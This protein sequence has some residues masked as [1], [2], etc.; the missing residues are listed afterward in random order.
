M[1]VDS[2]SERP[3]RGLQPYTEEDREYFFGRD[4]DRVVIA[5]NLIASPL[6]IL[7]GAS[8]VGKTSVLLA[9]VVPYL[10]AQAAASPRNT[11]SSRLTT[12]TFRAWQRSDFPLAL[13]L[14]VLNAVRATRLREDGTDS[15]I[16]IDP[17]LPLDEYLS[18]CIDVLEGR[19]LFIF[20]QFEEYFLNALNLPEIQR[21]EAEFARVI[22][23]RDID[24][25]F[26]L[27]LREE[28]LSKLDRFQGRI[29][30]LLNNTLRIEHLSRETGRDAITK[31]L[32]RYNQKFNLTD[33]AKIKIEDTLVEAVLDK[34]TPQ[35]EFAGA[36]AKLLEQSS[37]AD[38]R[39]VETPVLQ[40]L[41]TTL[42]SAEMKQNSKV[43]RLQ[44]FNERLGGA[45]KIVS[46]FFNDVMQRLSEPER[47]M[48]ARIFQFLV[49]Q[50]GT[51]IA[52]EPKTLVSWTGLKGDNVEKDVVAL[53]DKLSGYQ[54]GPNGEKSA[55]QQDFRVVRKVTAP[56]H[57]DRYELFHDVLGGAIKEW[58]TNY[59]EAK[60]AGAEKRKQQLKGGWLATGIFMATLTAFTIWF[61]SDA[62]KERKLATTQLN[63]VKILYDAVTT[64][65][66]SVPFFQAV[67][68]GHTDQVRSAAFS[69]DMQLVVT[70]SA[71]GTARV[72]YAQLGALKFDMRGHSG[73]VN[74]A[75][76]SEDGKLIVTAGADRT[77]RVWDASNGALL[78][79]LQGHADN[80]TYAA[81]APNGSIVTA[82]Q[83]GTARI[84]DGQS[85]QTLHDLRG[86]TGP[87]NSATL[88]P[89]QTPSLLTAS[90]DGTARLWD[91]QSGATIQVFKV[92]PTVEVEVKDAAI[93][94]D[95]NL[96]VTANADNTASLFEKAS[97]QGVALLNGHTDVV[98]SASFSP[99]GQFVVTASAD[100]TAR[101]WDAKSGRSHVVLTG[102]R[103]EVTDA[104]FSSDG[105]WVITIS[106]DDTARVWEVA[107]GK[108]LAELRGH[109][110]DLTS[111]SLNPGGKRI[112]TAS[113][114]KTARVWNVTELS[115][116][117]IVKPKLTAEPSNYTGKC[118][119]TI[120]FTGTIEVAGSGGKVKYQFV[121]SSKERS[122][123][124]ELVFT[125]PGSKEVTDTWRLGDPYG[126]QTL[127]ILEPQE[128]SSD[129]A[130]FRINCPPPSPTPTPDVTASP[131]PETYSVI[132]EI[133]MERPR[134]SVPELVR[135]TVLD[136]AT[137]QQVYARWA[138]APS[139]IKLQL[140][141][142]HRYTVSA[143]AA[144]YRATREVLT[145]VGGKGG[146]VRLRLR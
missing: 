126:W 6:T 1:Q 116:M 132:C 127:K 143:S 121:R 78:H 110:A 39:G 103:D 25:H 109:T 11:T 95:G 70:A 135:V 34:A 80:V 60:L 64:L 108:A 96:V 47:E 88:V 134:P 115:T 123:P 139:S 35:S 12:V 10:N 50:S 111:L 20:D 15:E 19:L 117:E 91:I 85:G 86:H 40:I 57:P 112:A 23:R 113:V 62:R 17:N 46:S 98:N 3:Y 72:W 18:A 56:N 29:P 141:P 5:S 61:A 146:F 87:I 94:A 102:H 137:N 122:E 131:D 129:K 24:A 114:D 124:V 92:G 48:T 63:Q 4:G 58:R 76:F 51:K 125:S 41:L 140:K 130:E 83:D 74:Q 33:D 90:A 101:L 45:E 22:N 14:E 53:L 26:L 13:R 104:V 36:E 97:G 73:V 93:S 105:R 79:I 99:D 27:S 30:N 9:A 128:L 42:W 54:P 69:P 67:M 66:S 100:K 71:D 32:E 144:G 68:R 106:K 89:S 145:G 65:D 84:W 44:T 43:L 82:S 37:I 49:T 75:V 77:A 81:F 118:P 142:Q 133:D 31:P 119:A 136:S 21:F 7:Y 28:E 107:T 8:G 120:K 38:G 16:T 59:L 55:N 2:S 138:L 52:L